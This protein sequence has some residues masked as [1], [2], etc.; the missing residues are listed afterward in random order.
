MEKKII[1]VVHNAIKGS[2]YFLLYFTMTAVWSFSGIGHGI[3]R[4][5]SFS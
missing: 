2:F 1:M 3:K 5:K 4:D